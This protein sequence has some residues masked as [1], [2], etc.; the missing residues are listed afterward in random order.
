MATGTV[1]SWDD[2]KGWGFITMDGTGESVF[3]HHTAVFNDG[4]RSLQEGMR[5][6]FEVTRGRQIQAS[7]VR[8]LR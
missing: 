8:P 4:F 7:N 3:A 1:K 5:V 2:M 6:E